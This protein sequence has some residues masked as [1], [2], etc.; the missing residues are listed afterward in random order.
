MGNKN[1]YSELLTVGFLHKSPGQ[2]VEVNQR[3][4]ALCLDGAA[5]PA[6]PAAREL[7]PGLS[8]TWASSSC[9]LA[10]FSSS[11]SSFSRR[12]DSLASSRP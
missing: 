12:A 6:G 8:P 4:R 3:P 9:F 2:A 1:A 11:L 7:I 5:T 10:D